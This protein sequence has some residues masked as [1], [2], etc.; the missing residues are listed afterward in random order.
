MQQFAGGQCSRHGDTAV[1]ADHAAVAW[2]R[3]RVGDVRECDMPAASPIPR[4][5]V[6]LDTVW[7]LSRQMESHPS[8]LRHPDPTEAPIQPLNVTRFHSDL[9]KSFMYTGFTPRRAPVS[10][11]EK[12]LHRLCEIPQRL[13]LHRLT[14]GTKP[15]VLS[16]G[17]RQL[18]TL[19]HIAGSLAPRLPMPLLLHRQIPHIPRVPAVRQ[20]RL[21]LL[22]SRQQSKP[23]HIRTVTTG[24]DI[25]RNSATVR[26]EIGILLELKSIASSRRRPR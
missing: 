2:T 6:G 23:R 15:P 9:P 19:L 20:Q 10:A 1:D 4:N 14:S 25:S 26:V 13:L 3:D 5:P 22:S 18:R 12:G 21:L 17:L 8:D 24:T 7:H 11:L 16:T